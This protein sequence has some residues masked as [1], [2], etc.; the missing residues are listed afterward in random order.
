ME[1]LK[2]KLQRL[3]DA[4]QLNEEDRQWLLQY[5]D[6]TDAR[7]L[8]QLMLNRFHDRLKEKQPVQ[9]ERAVRI[10]QRI[11]EHI[12]IQPQQRS[13]FMRWLPRLAA[14][15]AACFLIAAGIYRM[16]QGYV[17]KQVL[18]RNI[19]KTDSRT[20]EA[21]P[22]GTKALLTLA[23]GSTIVLDDA[24]NGNLVQQGNTKVFKFNGKIDYRPSSSGSDSI[25]FNSI[26]IPRGGQYSVTLP[27]GSQVWLNA[28]SS[29]RFPTAFK[30]AERRVEITGEAY[31]EVAKNAAMPFVV[32]I[33]GSEVRVLGTH[34][35]IMA[36]QEET[37][38]K[39][40]LLEG[41]VQFTHGGSTNILRPGQQA[42]LRE[43][44]KVKVES[45]IDAEDVIAW[46]N[47]LFHFEGTDIRT[48]MRQLAR[49][50]DVDVVYDD[51]HMNER[52]HADIMRTAT[53]AEA[54]KALELTEKVK[55]EIKGKTVVVKHA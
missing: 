32:K 41:S 44:G 55:F 24:R 53:L 27:D 47:G 4:E 40:T 33:G 17:K 2:Q 15:C 13:G 1:D 10:L 21:R 36:Y 26:A 45:N 18:A 11:H 49:W 54:L 51:T 19:H 8:N 16:Q 48:V 5:L 12:G 25:M 35:N 37:S 46:K 34:F 14:A 22:G 29:I 50:Y 39:T 20:Y 38:M 3:L 9:E 7:E 43:D 6:T 30:G 23:D 42:R 28:A 52:F 31:F